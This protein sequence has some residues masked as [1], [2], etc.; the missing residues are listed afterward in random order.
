MSISPISQACASGLRR[1]KPVCKPG[2]S[3]GNTC[4][5][6]RGASSNAADGLVSFLNKPEVNKQQ[7]APQYCPVNANYI[8]WL[9]RAAMIGTSEESCIFCAVSD[10]N[11]A[12]A[13]IEL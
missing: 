8:A 10:D 1:L 12:R 11:S 7:L 2:G 6:I 4:E 13:I 9:A 5:P 3:S